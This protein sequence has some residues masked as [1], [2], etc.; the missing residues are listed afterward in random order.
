MVKTKNHVFIAFCPYLCTNFKHFSKISCTLLFIYKHTMFDHNNNFIFGIHFMELV[1]FQANEC[2]RLHFSKQ[3]RTTIVT[4]QFIFMSFVSRFWYKLFAK[5]F[6]IISDG[7]GSVNF[8][9]HP[10][11][12]LFLCN[13]KIF[14][15]V[16]INFVC[17]FYKLSIGLI[18]SAF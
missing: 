8:F 17:G 12:C 10:A 15:D 13:I 2:E 9:P 5:S 14:N 7:F 18:L 3:K 4:I 1:T 16:V 6:Q 11:E